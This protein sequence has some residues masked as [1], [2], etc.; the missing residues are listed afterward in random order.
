MGYTTIHFPN[1]DSFLDFFSKTRWDMHSQIRNISVKA[2][3]FVF[4]YHTYHLGEVLPLIRG[5]RLDRLT[6]MDALHDP[7]V[8]VPCVN[9][10]LIIR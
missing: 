5:L 7:H 6:V 3:P 10:C 4:R 8:N 9:V 2:V 1:P